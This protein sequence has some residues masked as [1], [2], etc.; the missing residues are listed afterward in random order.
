MS[1]AYQLRQQIRDRIVA[2]VA[3]VTADDVIIDRQHD[4]LSAIA[5]AVSSAT[6][7]VAITILPARGKTRD[8]RSRALVLDTTVTVAMWT[9]PLLAGELTDQPEEDIHEAVMDALH[10]HVCEIV[11]AE[12]SYGQRLMV[13]EFFEVDDP[14]YLRRDTIITTDLVNIARPTS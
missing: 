1:R 13:V 10:H 12:R 2:E 8:Q 5:M 9:K 4:I 11:I 3:G 6:N 7:G 14:E